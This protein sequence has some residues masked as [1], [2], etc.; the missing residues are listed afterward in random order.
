MM[1]I[2]LDLQETYEIPKLPICYN[3]RH[4]EDIT[5]T[6]NNASS[7]IS[8]VQI[9]PVQYQGPHLLNVLTIVDLVV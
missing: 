1:A 8:T 7:F 4:D 2:L 6:H 5:E 3:H 9:Q